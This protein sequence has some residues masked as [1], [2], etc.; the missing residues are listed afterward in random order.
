MSNCINKNHPDVAK[1]AGELNILPAVAAAKIGVWQ[2]K[3]NIF[4]RF[5]TKDELNKKEEVN[6][7]LKAVDILSSDKAKQVF[8]KGQKNKWSLDKILTEL[9][10]PKEQKQLI[11]SRNLEKTQDIS[12]KN[13]VQELFNSNPELS[14]LGTPQQYS[15]YLETIFPN[16]KVKDIVY[17]GSDTKFEDFLED[18]LNYFGTK[19][20][21]K[22]YGKNLY[23][24]V[25][26]IKKPYYEDGGN[27]SNQ[28]YEDL[29]DKLDES[30][31]DGFISNGKNI[32]V[33]KTEEQIHI[34]GSK[35]D[36]EGFKNFLNKSNVFNSKESDIR[37]QIVTDL[38]ANYSYTV[39]IN[40][41][42]DK[43]ET[44]LY[45]NEYYD[46]ETGETH[47]LSTDSKIIP[48][49]GNNSNY[50]RG[51]TVPGGTNY[52]EN[53]ISTPLIT[54]S[55]KGHAQFATDNGIGWHRSDDR[56]I[57]IQQMLKSG[58]IK[59]VPCK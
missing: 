24:V 32:F 28:S 7:N 54:P 48:P 40:T 51:L 46:E 12:T 16:S 4:D 55:I 42:K 10:I 35:Q 18:N 25:I 34:L 59:E 17:H 29:Y 21:A 33:P 53:E 57:D 45:A 15:Q 19:E 30:G 56:V 39:E 11:L 22:G 41:A 9:Q 58:L 38:L 8:D 23:P 36:I 27:L 50:Y 31:S 2:S 49:T 47:I 13:G 3:N 6:Y 14:K 1:L 43:G 26:E 52:T 20:I 37:E 44:V 5:P